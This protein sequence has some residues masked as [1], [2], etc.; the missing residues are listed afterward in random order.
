[1]DRH[2]C[3][4]L[5]I[6]ALFLLVTGGIRS[7]VRGKVTWANFYLGLDLSLAALANGL[8]NVADILHD[9]EKNAISGDIAESRTIYTLIFIILSGAVLLVVM[10]IHQRWEGIGFD[11]WG[12]KHR[13]IRGVMLGVLSNILGLTTLLGFIWFRLKGVL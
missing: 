9:V 11:V 4:T 2:L 13:G 6:P 1:M 10:L 5:V 12:V 3:L 8:V 7:L